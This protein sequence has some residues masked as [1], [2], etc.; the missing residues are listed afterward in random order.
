MDS[1]T[2]SERRLHHL[3]GAGLIAFA[4]LMAAMLIPRTQ[5]Q[6]NCGDPS[7]G[8]TWE[9]CESN[10]LD[11]SSGWYDENYQIL[12]RQCTAT[13][14]NTWKKCV[15]NECPQNLCPDCGDDAAPGC[16]S[17]GVIDG[18]DPIELI[19]MRTPTCPNPTVIVNVTYN[20]DNTVS[21][22]QVLEKN[23]AKQCGAIP[24]AWSCADPWDLDDCQEDLDDACGNQ[25]T[26]ITVKESKTV[27]AWDYT[28][29]GN[30][31]ASGTRQAFVTCRRAFPAPKDPDDKLQ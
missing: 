30:C 7:P 3:I 21:I 16:A 15:D 19:D 10:A 26:N 28:C 25:A 5:A 31:N 24:G 14:C 6:M 18:P 22:A 11:C 20:P 1:M 17:A 13:L 12:V 29:G 27:G 2:R 23:G 8:T 9:E 4:V